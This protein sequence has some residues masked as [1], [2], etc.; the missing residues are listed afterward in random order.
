MELWN[1]VKMEYWNQ[2]SGRCSKRISFSDMMYK[3]DQQ[4]QSLKMIWGKSP[5][6]V[7]VVGYSGSGKTTLLEKLI[8]EL[9]G[10]GYSVGTIKHDVH[11]FEMDRPGKDS[12]RHKKAGA[13]TTIISSPY[14]IGM[15]RDVDYDYRPEEL[16]ALLP[17]VDII[18]TEGYKK[19]NLPKLEV[20]RSQVHKA[21]LFKGDKTL[22]ALI[23]DDPIDVGVPRFSTDDGK[24]VVDFLIG[25]FNLVKAVSLARTKAAS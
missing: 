6:V 10:R 5:P 16:M 23:S 8:S 3:N 1:G 13:S 2:K 9:K 17:D 21:P 12:W 25:Y 20:F 22:L 24:S 14:Q 7:S 11:G 4:N 18:L 19:E 15:V